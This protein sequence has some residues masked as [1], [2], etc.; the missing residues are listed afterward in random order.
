[1]SNPKVFALGLI[2]FGTCKVDGLRC[3]GEG[4]VCRFNPDDTH[5]VFIDDMGHCRPLFN[6]S[7]SNWRKVV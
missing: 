1:V 4:M 5:P 2:V 6:R 7:C 3:D